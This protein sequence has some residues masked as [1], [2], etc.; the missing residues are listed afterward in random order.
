M[1]AFE[2]V[3]NIYFNLFFLSLPLLI[4]GCRFFSWAWKNF[5]KV[6]WGFEKHRGDLQE[7]QHEMKMVL[8]LAFSGISVKTCA[9][10]NLFRGF[11]WLGA[12]YH[13]K[14]L[15]IYKMLK[16]LFYTL[17]GSD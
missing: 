17:T 6:A 16:V 13:F 7:K 12:I 2:D 10:Y 15:G 11:S 8:A 14:A 1:F 3:Q 9:I 5:G 4:L